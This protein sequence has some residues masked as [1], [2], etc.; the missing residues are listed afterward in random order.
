VHV[1]IFLAQLATREHVTYGSVFVL[2][3]LCV[4]VGV[5]CAVFG[6]ITDC[7]RGVISLHPH[8]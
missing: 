6:I 4:V 7:V 3:G 1:Y 8:Q 2:C 5:S